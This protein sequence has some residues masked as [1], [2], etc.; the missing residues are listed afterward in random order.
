MKPVHHTYLLDQ[1]DSFLQVHSEVDEL[2]VDAL[3]LVLLLL[4]HEHMVVEELLQTLVRVVDEQLLQGVE[5]QA[6]PEV[7]GRKFKNRLS[8]D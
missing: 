7:T 2:P 4:Q 6:K 3:F 5:L 8:E 1:L